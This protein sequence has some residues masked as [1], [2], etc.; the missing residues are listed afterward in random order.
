[1]ILPSRKIEKLKVIAFDNPNRTGRGQDFIFLIQPEQMR[2]RHQN[3]FMKRRG[4]NTSGRS[5]EY[6]FSFS[7]EL[8]LELILDNTLLNNKLPGLSA[9]GKDTIREQVD[10]FLSRCFYMDGKIHEPRFLTVEWGEMAFEC[11]LKSADISY[12]TFDDE[13]KPLRAILQT[14]FIEDLPVGKRL[15]LENK[16]SPDIT[17]SRMVKQGDTLTGLCKEVY[18]DATLYMFVAEANQLDHFRLLKPGDVL[19]FPPLDK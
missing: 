13:G 7:D 5:A 12:S 4:I 18:G 3:H 9:S 8:T 15:K 11:R 17:H 16:Q 6:A 1:M 2:S 14:V 19:R 10:T